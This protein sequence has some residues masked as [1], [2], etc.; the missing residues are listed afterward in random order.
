MFPDTSHDRPGDSDLDAPAASKQLAR[1]Q[2]IR[3]IQRR[4][5][6]PPDRLAW[7]KAWGL[8]LRERSC[9]G[10]I[11]VSKWTGM[12][13]LIRIDRTDLYRWS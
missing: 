13:P 1:Q 10:T 3:Q 7:D 6:K 12:R 2:A 4:R 8:R 11:Q 9:E 5:Q